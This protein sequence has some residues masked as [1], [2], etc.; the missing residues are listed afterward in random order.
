MQILMIC[1]FPFFEFYFSVPKVGASQSSFRIYSTETFTIAVVVSCFASL[2]VGFLSGLVFSRR[3]KLG[4]YFSSG[5]FS[6]APYL[7]Q[8]RLSRLNETVGSCSEPSKMNNFV[9]SL[10]NV[11]KLA[12][13]KNNAAAVNNAG[14]LDL[15]PAVQKVKKTY[16]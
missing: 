12:N 14:T 7:E 5:S 3:C 11:V 2:V 15:K 10:Q 1:S 16:V 13:E 9:D 4:D 8:R 6:G